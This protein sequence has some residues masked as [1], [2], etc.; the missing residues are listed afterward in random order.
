[1]MS[2]PP[3]AFI[4]I[5]P[6]LVC[7]RARVIPPK[8]Q[9]DQRGSEGLRSAVS[10]SFSSFFFFIYSARVNTSIFRKGGK[11]R[12]SVSGA[13]ITMLPD[14]HAHVRT[15]DITKQRAQPRTLKLRSRK[16]GPRG[17]SFCLGLMSDFKRREK[18][19]RFFVFLF[20]FASISMGAAC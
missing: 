14:T 16:I 15:H 17:R 10:D 6:V 13:I 12:V 4:C 1:M 18:H 20:F 11:S 3:R 19:L 2:T 9:R 8:S 5:S 7:V